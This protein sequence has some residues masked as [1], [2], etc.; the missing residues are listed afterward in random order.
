MNFGPG[1]TLTVGVVHG[2]LEGH[3]RRVVGEVVGEDEGR[4]EVA[5]L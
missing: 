5:A 2:R 4:L 3:G 1:A